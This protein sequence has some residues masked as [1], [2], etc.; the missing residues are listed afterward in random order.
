[1]KLITQKGNEM[2]KELS[3]NR[4]RLTDATFQIGNELYASPIAISGEISTERYA[5]IY[6]TIGE[7]EN[8]IIHIL[9]DIDRVLDYKSLEVNRFQ[10]FVMERIL[11]IQL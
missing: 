2:L 11:R 3:R 9:G 1:M 5:K 4:D 10:K 6:T 7:A 8:N